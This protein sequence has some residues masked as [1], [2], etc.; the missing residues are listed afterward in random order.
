LRGADLYG[1][2]IN[3]SQIQTMLDVLNFKI[4]EDKWKL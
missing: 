1:A 3:E 2:T 4:R